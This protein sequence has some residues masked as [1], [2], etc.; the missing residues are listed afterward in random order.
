MDES[1]ACLVQEYFGWREMNHEITKGTVNLQRRWE[2]DGRE[3][4]KIVDFIE[5]R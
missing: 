4:P 3:L 2:L 5:E 1:R